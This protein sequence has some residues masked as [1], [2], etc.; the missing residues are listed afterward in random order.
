LREV[1]DGDGKVFIQAQSEILRELKISSQTHA[2]I[3][4]AMAQVVN[5]PKGTAGRARLP[6]ITVGGKTG[7]AENPHGD[8]T[9]ALFICAAPL[10]N[11]RIAIAVVIENIGHGGSFAA[12]LAGALLKRFFEHAPRG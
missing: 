9:H 6:D 8:L 7:S 12:P 3:L 10:E 5:S 11:P 1:L 2:A 4:Q